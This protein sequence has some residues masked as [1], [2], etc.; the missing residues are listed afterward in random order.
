MATLHTRTDG[1]L[2]E[3]GITVSTVVTYTPLRE[4]DQE[5]L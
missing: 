4:Q 5:N 1:P 2:A 3:A